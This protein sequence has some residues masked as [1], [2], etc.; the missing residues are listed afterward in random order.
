MLRN[1][2]SAYRG[3]QEAIAIFASRLSWSQQ[4]EIESVTSRR[5]APSNFRRGVSLCSGQR[6]LRSLSRVRSLKAST[7]AL[8]AA[9]REGATKHFITNCFNRPACSQAL[10]WIGTRLTRRG[11]RAVGAAC[12][13]LC[14][15][16]ASERLPDATASLRRAAGRRAWA[17][18]D[19]PT[20]RAV[21]GLRA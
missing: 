17:L 4:E 20:G 2:R 1:H 8:A 3:I 14:P 6:T 7:S 10:A 19:A 15:S 21:S 5:D 12:R 9:G 16:C 18:A 11:S 13:A